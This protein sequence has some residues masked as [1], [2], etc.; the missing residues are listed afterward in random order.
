[1]KS[2]SVEFGCSI[3]DLVMTPAGDHGSIES[4]QLNRDDVKQVMVV[5]VD[6]TGKKKADWFD[7]GACVDTPSEFT[8]SAKAVSPP[9]VDPPL[10]VAQPVSPPPA[11][12]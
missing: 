9:I 3:G 4:L 12:D 8:D 6:G 10:T 2:C 11:A 1:M 5:W 7:A